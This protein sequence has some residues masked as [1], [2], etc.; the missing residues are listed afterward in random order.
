M[1][2]SVGNV[3]LASDFNLIKARVK[4][5]C[6][7]RKYV[8]SVA[9]YAS[10]DYDYAEIPTQGENVLPEHWNKIIIPMNQIMDTGFTT[11]ESGD[12]VQQLLTLSNLLG[13]L[14]NEATDGA[15]SSCRSTCTGL[16]V[17]AC[18]S[19]CMGCTGGCASTCS[20]SCTGGCSGCSSCSGSCVGG[21]RTEACK[22]GCST[23]GCKGG[24]CRTN[25]SAFCT[26]NTRIADN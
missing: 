17:G 14:E 3:I 25:C 9:S 24:H 5:E 12:V 2:L 19:G 16:C 18:S 21:C 4:A 1:G 26:N 8:G 10:A 11:K 20:Q 6:A 15:V 23:E 7:R 22:G 13:Q